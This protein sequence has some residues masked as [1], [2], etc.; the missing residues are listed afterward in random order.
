M[1]GCRIGFVGAGAVA[2]RHARILSG[3][4][5][6]RLVAVTDPATARAQSFADTYGTRAV[7]GLPELLS[8]DLDAV[9][10]CVP[11]FAHGQLEEA[12]AAAGVA[13]FVE[14]PLGLDESTPEQVMA[15]VLR[16]GIVTA[17][18]HHWRYAD[19]VRRAQRRVDHRAVRLVLGAWLDTLPPVPWWARRSH[20]GGQVI[21]AAHQAPR[22]AGAL[23]R[24]P[25]AGR[26][27]DPPPGPRRHRG[28]APL[29][30]GSDGRQ[31]GDRPGV[32]GRRRRPGDGHP[33]A[34]R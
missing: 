4:S 21:E 8:A 7:P 24:R 20:S 10:V 1:T 14:K 16:F 5:D 2:E 3:F 31:A 27:R 33:D 9:Y 17:V 12:V 34:L 32:R 25:R 28:T 11:P 29:V 23:R 22:G 13:L 15:A 19:T 26:D 6:V 18:G 30:G